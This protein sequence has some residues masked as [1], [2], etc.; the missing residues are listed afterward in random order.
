[1]ASRDVVFDIGDAKF[2]VGIGLPTRVVEKFVKKWKEEAE[3]GYDQWTEGSSSG[4]E[5]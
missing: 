3:P 2:G 4:E 1:M 5:P